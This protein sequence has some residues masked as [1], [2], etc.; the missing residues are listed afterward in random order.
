MSGE[1]SPST[2][3]RGVY[4]AMGVSADAEGDAVDVPR[5]GSA[6]AT[7][8]GAGSSGDRDCPACGGVSR[9]VRAGVYR[10]P[11]HGQWRAS[12]EG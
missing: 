6:G 3:W 1:S 7:A 4:A 12:A 2:G 9:R 10:C 8:A 11:E 5:S